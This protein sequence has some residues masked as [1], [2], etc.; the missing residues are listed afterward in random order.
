MLASDFIKDLTKLIEEHGDLPVYEPYNDLE[1]VQVF[2]EEEV[3]RFNEKIKRPHFR[4]SE[5]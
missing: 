4:V 3:L 5:I 2:Y 1:L